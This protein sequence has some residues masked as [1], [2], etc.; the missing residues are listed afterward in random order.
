VLHPENPLAKQ[1]AATALIYDLAV[2]TRNSAHYDS[3]GV[4]I[5]NPFA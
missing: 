4:Q 2:V 5:V 1:I 3:T